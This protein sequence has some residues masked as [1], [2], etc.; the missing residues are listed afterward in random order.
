MV[1]AIIEM[2]CYFLFL[3]VFANF[4]QNLLFEKNGLQN[5]QKFVED[6]PCGVCFGKY[7]LSELFY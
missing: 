3:P 1:K 6:A 2:S 7:I 5:F 4:Y